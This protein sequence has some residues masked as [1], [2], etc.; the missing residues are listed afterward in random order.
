MSSIPGNSISSALARAGQT[1]KPNTPAEALARLNLRGPASAEW[2]DIIRLNANGVARV[3]R[4]IDDERQALEE[5]YGNGTKAV[6]ALKQIDEMLTE[7]DTLA[8]ENAKTATGPRARKRN[9]TKINTLLEKID[10]T[11]ADAGGEGNRVL[12]GNTALTSGGR[13][14]LKTQSLDL[15]R[16]SPETLG[17]ITAGGRSLRLADLASRK[18][19][20]TATGRA[21]SIASARRSVEA[22]KD[23]IAE[24]TAEIQTFQREQLRPRLGDVAT[25]MEGIYT[26]TSLGSGEEAMELARELRQMMLSSATIAVGVAADDW[27]RERVIDV[28]T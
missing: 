21:S 14:A 10:T 28:L 16:I 8:K 23:Q 3:A 7:V 17:R 18:P 5:S 4:A 20:D 26:T 1:D 2:N 12:A 11:A 19:L 22:A 24:M 27:D 13:A 25:A 15:E 6:E 9:Q